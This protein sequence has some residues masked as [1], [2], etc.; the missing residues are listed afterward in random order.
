MSEVGSRPRSVLPSGGSR[1]AVSR[2]VVSAG[3]PRGGAAS[4]VGSRDDTA[5]LTRARLQ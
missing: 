3:V 1:G 4:A 2:R 5:I